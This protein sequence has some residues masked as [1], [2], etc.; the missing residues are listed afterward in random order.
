MPEKRVCVWKSLDLNVDDPS[1][2]TQL[3][4]E[5]GAISD[6]FN[7]VGKEEGVTIWRVTVREFIYTQ[8]YNSYIGIHS[9]GSQTLSSAQA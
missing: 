8:G 6:A 1:L 4:Q 2:R 3:Q 5:G 7:S 9:K